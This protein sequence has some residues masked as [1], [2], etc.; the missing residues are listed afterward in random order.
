MPC[1]GL[2]ASEADTTWGVFQSHARPRAAC[3]SLSPDAG[4]FADQ[5]PLGSGSGQPER[6]ASAREGRA[7]FVTLE[8]L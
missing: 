8:T 3:R 7:G 6:A 5:P 4:S 2:S 1:L